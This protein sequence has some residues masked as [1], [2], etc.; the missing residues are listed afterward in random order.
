MSV[1]VSVTELTALKLADNLKLTSLASLKQLKVVREAL[2]LRG[3][4]KL[5]A[6]TGLDNHESVGASIF[7]DT[8]PRRC[9]PSRQGLRRCAARAQGKG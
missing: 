6:I 5:V 9:G 8:A 2:I 3:H 4:P 1:L 7:D